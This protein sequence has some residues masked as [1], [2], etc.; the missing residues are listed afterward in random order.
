MFTKLVDGKRVEVSLEEE[1]IILV[2]QSTRSDIEA[3]YLDSIRLTRDIMLKNLDQCWIRALR[4]KDI[5][6][7]QRLEAVAQELADIPQTINY[8]GMTDEEIKEYKPEW[9]KV[10]K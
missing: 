10:E 9:P 7:Q 2:E 1:A 8:N 5:Q 4:Q 6:E 3:K